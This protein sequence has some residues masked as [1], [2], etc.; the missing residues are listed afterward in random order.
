MRSLKRN[1]ERSETTTCL[2]NELIDLT[3]CLFLFIKRVHFYLVPAILNKIIRF[4]TN[5]VKRKSATSVFIHDRAS[6]KGLYF[7]Y[8]YALNHSELLNTSSTEIFYNIHQCLRLYYKQYL[9]ALSVK[10]CYFS[11]SLI[12]RSKPPLNI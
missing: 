8:N 9:Y 2:F 6:T 1:L 11:I 5:D 4:S 7:I 12:S 3:F 10:I